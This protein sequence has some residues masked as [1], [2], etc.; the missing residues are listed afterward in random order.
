[1]TM[2]TK[3]QR[4]IAYHPL[5]TPPAIDVLAGLAAKAVDI[6]DRALRFGETAPEPSDDYDYA[7]TRADFSPEMLQL[8]DDGEALWKA[9]ESTYEFLGDLI[10]DVFGFQ[11]VLDSL[12][13]LFGQSYWEHQPLVAPQG[14]EEL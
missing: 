4:A 14:P 8:L 3:R 10:Y 2:T 1:M 13:A 12:E 7:P 5:E 11:E 9:I 6:R